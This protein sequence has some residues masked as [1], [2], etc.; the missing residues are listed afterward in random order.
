MHLRVRQI[1]HGRVIDLNDAR[2]G[3]HLFLTQSLAP[4]S[5]PLHSNSTFPELD[6]IWDSPQQRVFLPRIQERPRSLLYAPL[7]S[8]A[9]PSCE[10]P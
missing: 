10:M 3:G 4:E 9:S 1:K 2:G 8:V 7:S 5:P 6:F